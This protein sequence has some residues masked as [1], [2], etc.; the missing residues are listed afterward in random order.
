[1]PCLAP[2]KVI[3]LAPYADAEIR[4]LTATY[5]SIRQRLDAI[6]DDGPGQRPTLIPRLIRELDFL[7]TGLGAIPSRSRSGLMAKIRVLRDSMA[8][9]GSTDAGS[10]LL[11]SVLSDV[12]TLLGPSSA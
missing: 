7:R 12:E 6:P 9:V 8:T 4:M 1:M 3:Q 11:A 5:T 2:S 10:T